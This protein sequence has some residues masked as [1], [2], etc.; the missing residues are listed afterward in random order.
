MSKVWLG[1]YQPNKICNK[2]WWMNIHQMFSNTSRA[3]KS[4]VLRCFD[5]G[6]TYI[7]PCNHGDQ[8]CLSGCLSHDWRANLELFFSKDR[9]QRGPSTSIQDNANG[10]LMFFDHSI[11]DHMAS[12][13]VHFVYTCSV[14]Y[15]WRRVITVVLDVSFLEMQPESPVRIPKTD[16]PAALFTRSKAQLL[17]NHPF[18]LGWFFSAHKPPFDRVL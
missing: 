2:V 6:H 17:Q 15:P 3:E 16:L 7:A 12:T 5:L 9:L 11:R 4:S 1:T 13:G 10:F 14:N 18:F 8:W